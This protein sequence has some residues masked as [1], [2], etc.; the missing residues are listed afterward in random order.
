MD[1]YMLVAY[2]SVKLDGK[3]TVLAYYISSHF[4]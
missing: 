3:V 2:G 1:I 4:S